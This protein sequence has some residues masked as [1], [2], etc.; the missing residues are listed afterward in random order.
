MG[1]DHPYRTIVARAMT[2]VRA[3]AP[4]KLNLGLEVIG[5]RLDGYHNIA[6]V[7]QTVTVFDR[8]TVTPAPEI[9]LTVADRS[10]AGEDNLAFAAARLVRNNLGLPDGASI[11]LSKRIP[12]AAGL[13]GASS[14][15]AAT[16]VALSRLG[17]AALEPDVMRDLAAR[18]GSDV[19]FLLSGGTAL[20]EGR[21]EAVT[22]LRPL[23][24]IWFVLAVPAVSISRKTATLYARLSPGDFTSGDRVRRL[25][26]DVEAGRPLAPDLLANAFRRPLLKLFPELVD[27]ERLFV[28]AGADF[29]ALSGSGPTLYTVAAD[30]DE[31]LSI[32]RKLRRT[33][34]AAT[35][36]MVCRPVRRAPLI[37]IDDA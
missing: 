12:A 17:K 26:A 15:A 7:M 36:I 30:A 14:D 5:K 32:A 9:T 28:V 11:E 3:L 33:L 1:R 2:T 29:V 27:V 21:G 22:T 13:G 23:A 19:P 31:G 34:P 8:L 25:T 24:G 6:T 4:A 20:V 18:L 16:L 35:R 37:R 10:L